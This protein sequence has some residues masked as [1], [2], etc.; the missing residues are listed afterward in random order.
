[1]LSK[2]V[3]VQTRHVQVLGALLVL[4]PVGL[5]AGIGLAA[6]HLAWWGGWLLLVALI[7]ALSPFMTAMWQFL[8]MQA[9]ALAGVAW[10]ASAL[11]LRLDQEQVVR[12]LMEL[13]LLLWALLV[14]CL[15]IYLVAL[16]R[17]RRLRAHAGYGSSVPKWNS[18]G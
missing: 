15:A 17:T 10:T 12:G 4:Y 18:S 1:M 13:P 6:L 7:L 9:A 3:R 16:I 2:F 5:L 11:T 14:N 8:I